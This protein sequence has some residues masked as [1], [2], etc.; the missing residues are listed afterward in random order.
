MSSDNAEVMPAPAKRVFISLPKKF[1]PGLSENYELDHGLLI[2]DLNPFINE[3]YI[4]VYFREW[5]TVTSCKVKKIPNSDKT[6]AYVLFSS[7][8]EADRADWAG[9][10]YIGG[11]EVS[12]RR[13]VSP[14]CEGDTGEELAAAATKP[15]ARRSMGLGYILEDAQWLDDE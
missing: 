4:V 5:G 14:K 6:L 8:D 13:I 9:P 2:R 11:M 3:G 1:I 7:E 12:V 15:P 10:H